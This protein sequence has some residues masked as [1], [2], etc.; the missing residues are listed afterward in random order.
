[1]GRRQGDSF[2]VIGVTGGIGAG[3][4]TVS[5]QLVKMGAMLLDADSLSREVTAPG[6]PAVA[7][8]VARFGTEVLDGQGQLNR[9][10][11]ASLVFSD[12]E[13]RQALEAI[14]H[15]QVVA[16]IDKALAALRQQVWH[17]V[18]VLDVP[19][20]VSRGFLDV[21]DEVWVVESPVAE[22]IARVRQRSGLTESQIR[23][24]MD[25]QLGEAEW[26]RLAD[27]LID[28]AGNQEALARKVA[29]LLRE[30]CKA[31]KV[32]LPRQEPLPYHMGGASGT[33]KSGGEGGRVAKTRVEAE[34]CEKGSDGDTL[35]ARAPHG[36]ASTQEDH[37][38]NQPMFERDLLYPTDV[39]FEPGSVHVRVFA[40]ESDGRM[41]VHIEAKT[42][43][44]LVD[45]IEPIMTLMQSDIFDRIRMDIRRSGVIY[46][47]PFAEGETICVRY[48]ENG[49]SHST[50]V[51]HEDRNSAKA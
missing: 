26:H 10:T 45:Y 32:S 42:N 15:A 30:A 33:E 43:H 31:W 28:N 29:Q 20:P 7:E 50:K 47:H 48:N 44:D 6:E 17:G 16:A 36:G 5:A 22:R 34:P 41:P 2:L 51:I 49:R 8:I 19:I 24:R 18:V 12:S 38:M 1:M 14:I 11:L 27:R 13:R 25:A 39:L 35:E 21:S 46:L 9:H 40:P 3:K 23:A 4:S 37:A